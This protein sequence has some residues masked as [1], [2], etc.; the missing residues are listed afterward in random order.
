MTGPNC[1]RRVA[2]AGMAALPFAA[3]MARAQTAPAGAI[4][5]LDPALDAVIDAGAPIEIL[6]TGYKWAE[7]P[8]WVRQGDFLLF[9]DVP[10]NICYRWKEGEGIAPFLAP[11]G[12]EGAVAEGAGEQGANGLAIDGNGDLVMADS[13]NRAIARVPLPR[14]TGPK[15]LLARTYKGKRFNSCNDLTIARDGAIYFTDPPYG[16]AKG[17]E[18]PLKELAFNGVYRLGTDGTVRLLEDGLSRP[19]GIGLSPDER[20]LYVA[21]S[22]EK[23]PQ[24][25]AY[26]LDSAGNVS[27]R[28]VFHDFAEPLARKL[29]GLPDGLKVDPAGRVFA[30]GPGGV[31]VLSPEGKALGMIATGK[32]IANCAFGGADGR[33][34]FMTS[35]DM[36]ARVR[37]KSAGW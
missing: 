17:D 36:L 12:N 26:D 10:S 35:H 23:R 25:L 31:W 14:G 28:R 32:A 6:G 21:M 4:A 11:S 16:L 8:I 30:T 29:P 27:N 19:N 9:N 13:G 3:G 1:T 18:S 24:V 37:L 15:T 2:L 34:L 22:D 7:G 33:T 5:R 20:T